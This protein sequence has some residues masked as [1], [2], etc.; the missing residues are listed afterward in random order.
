MN[1]NL[2]CY[3]LNLSSDM[4]YKIKYMNGKNAWYLISFKN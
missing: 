1:L 4:L 2:V 3:Y